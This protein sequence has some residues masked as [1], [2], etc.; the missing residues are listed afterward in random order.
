MGPIKYQNVRAEF[1]KFT[2]FALGIGMAV[3]RTLKSSIL[4]DAAFM[5]WTV[6]SSYHRSLNIAIMKMIMMKT[7]MP[8]T[9]IDTNSLE[10]LNE[11]SVC[12]GSMVMVFCSQRASY[13][14]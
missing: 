13:L 14:D 1:T 4:N 6:S 11:P 7:S 9:I 5:S 3:K 12:C 10:S 8:T 2:Y